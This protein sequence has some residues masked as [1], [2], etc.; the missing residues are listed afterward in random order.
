MFF[1][2]KVKSFKYCFYKEKI[3]IFFFLW[4]MHDR[5][6]IIPQLKLPFNL[7]VCNFCP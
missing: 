2:F 7:L 5:F 6:F 1:L 3:K 4:E